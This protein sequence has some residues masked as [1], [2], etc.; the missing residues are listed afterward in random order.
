MER[1]EFKD[2]LEDKKNAYNYTFCLIL[3]ST[4]K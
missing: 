3:K 4:I 2:K 1:N